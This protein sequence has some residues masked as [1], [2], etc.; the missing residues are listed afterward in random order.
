MSA[1]VGGALLGPQSH[2]LQG[3][4]TVALDLDETLVHYVQVSD[5]L[6]VR[7]HCSD[8]LQKA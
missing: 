2:A 4:L 6:L 7:P 1:Q 8:L 5:T 3:R